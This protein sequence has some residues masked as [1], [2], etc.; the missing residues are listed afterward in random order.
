VVRKPKSGVRTPYRL[1]VDHSVPVVVLREHILENR[2]LWEPQSLEA[3][4]E[5]WYR[6]GVL[7][8]DQDRQL[9]EAGL[10]QRMPSGWTFGNDPFAR[11]TKVG[12]THA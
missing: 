6:R 2:S 9:D 12:L 10:R 4:L 7:T 8:K 11:Y 3:F 5:S 1:I